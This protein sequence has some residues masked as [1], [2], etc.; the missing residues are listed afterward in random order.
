M[1]CTFDMKL[2]QAAKDGEQVEREEAEEMNTGPTTVGQVSRK[3]ATEEARSNL[4]EP[5][6]T[7]EKH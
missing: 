3:P 5:R 6:R 7:A 4:G 1:E 2:G